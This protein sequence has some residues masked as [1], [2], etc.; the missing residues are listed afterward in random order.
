[1]FTEQD[2]ILICFAVYDIIVELWDPF[3]L[4]IIYSPLLLTVVTNNTN[5]IVMIKVLVGELRVKC[6]MDRPDSV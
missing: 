3:I 5:N 6:C 4:F 2:H 1:M